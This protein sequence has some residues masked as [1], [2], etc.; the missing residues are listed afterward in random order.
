MLT[1]I[2]SALRPAIV[3]LVL[4]TL[5]LGLAF[6]LGITGIAQTV[7]PAQANGSLIRDEGKIV[8]SELIGQGFVQDRYFHSRLSAAGDGYDASASAASNLAPGSK[9]LAERIGTDV[10]ALREKGMTGL[11]PVD[12]VTTSASGLDPH[13]SPEAALLQVERVAT[14]RGVSADAVRKA[15]TAA[16]EYPLF[17]IMGEPRVNVLLLNRQ[18]DRLSANQ[19]K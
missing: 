15:V 3:L 2:R 5:L 1:E 16:S 17:G 11:V 18:L 10:A 6:P 12:L 13:I 19:V 14:A 9:D 7:M 8:G 4:F